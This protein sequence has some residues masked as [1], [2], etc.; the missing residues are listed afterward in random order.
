MSIIKGTVEVT[1]NLSKSTCYFLRTGKCSLSVVRDFAMSAPG[2]ISKNDLLYCPRLYRAM[3]NRE[4]MKPITVTPCECGHAEVVSG[5]QRACIA[6]QKNLELSIQPAGP[7]YK[8]DC[9]LCSGQIT[10]EENSGSNRI[11]ALR[12]RVEDE[13]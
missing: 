2:K 9:P 7:E 3:C 1:L 13:E 8:A 5:H 4:R 12:V 11:V 6:S 10:F